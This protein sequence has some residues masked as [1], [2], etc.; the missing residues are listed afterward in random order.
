M[1]V[2]ASTDT[3][4]APSPAPATTQA[5]SRDERR[6]RQIA[7]L[8]ASEKPAAAEPEAPASAD[9]V[10][11]GALAEATAEAEGQ[12]AESP[13]A[14]RLA[15]VR[16]AIR[17]QAAKRQADIAAQQ[18]DQ[19]FTTLRGELEQ[20]R[21]RPSL[22]TFLAEFASAPAAT[23]RKYKLDPAQHLNL[24]TK[25]AI[26]P[27]SV[28]AESQLEQLRKEFVDDKTA[29]EQQ[30]QLE[31]QQRLAAEQQQRYEAERTAFS[32]YAAEAVDPETKAQRWP[33]LAKTSEAKRI[34]LAVAK[35]AELQDEGATS[36][37]RDL[38]ADAVEADLEDLH[39]SW[40]PP[41][42]PPVAAAAPSQVAT[43]KPTRTLTPAIA[44]ESGAPR[45]KPWSERKRDLAA[46]MRRRN[47]A[48]KDS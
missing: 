35:W 25:D 26:T 8:K 13:A 17:E 19:E 46:A 22:D 44:A 43:K 11:E 4:A 38:V 45:K 20:L 18:R 30:Q 40:T 31:Q 6:A 34:R 5:P 33:L 48:A 28:S 3:S 41:A 16:A 29:R 37:S 27:G 24:L 1:T 42:S 10:A 36:Y 47:D 2:E 21:G 14:K 23:L 9:G 39:Q 12:P 32:K 15:K 7:A